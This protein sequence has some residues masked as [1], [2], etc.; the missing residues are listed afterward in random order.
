MEV[1][2]Q[3]YQQFNVV[4][5]DGNVIGSVDGDV[6]Y[7]WMPFGIYAEAILVTNVDG[8]GP[9]VGSQI[10]FVNSPWK[11]WGA[12]YTAVPEGDDDVLAFTIVSPF[13]NIPIPAR[14]N[15]IKG[16]DDVTYY[17]PFV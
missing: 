8:E 6:T 2:V 4:D 7:Q 12:Y 10:N 16:F 14:Y 1:Q 3:G 13:G 11:H 5:S 15:A 17:D 9:P